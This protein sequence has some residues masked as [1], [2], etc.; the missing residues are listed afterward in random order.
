MPELPRDEEVQ[1]VI[2]LD[3]VTTGFTSPP[4]L[5]AAH[6]LDREFTIQA[7]SQRVLVLRRFL[8]HRL[9]VASLVVL[10]LFI[11]M[12]FVGGPLWKYSYADLVANPY[13]T[14]TWSHPLGSDQIGH[15]ELS[16]VLRGAQASLVV[17]FLVALIA[18]T[19]GTLVGAF[20]GFFGGVV[21]SV[22]MRIC[23]TILTLPT[24]AVAIVL[25]HNLTAISFV[26]QRVALAFI[27]GLLSWPQMARVVRGQLLSLRERDFV[28][29]ARALG[30]SNTRI[31]VRHLVPNVLGSI[32]VN[33]TIYV[34]VAILAESA[35]SFLGFGIQP[36]DT[37][38][39]LLISSAETE[40]SVHPW[41]F[42]SPGLAIIIVAL[43]V[44][45]IGDGLR[46]AFDPGQTQVRA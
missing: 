27:L 24:I 32:I 19:V 42:Y 10:A 33:S 14:P 38:L 44:N 16:L 13:Q 12:A 23:D 40:V 46:D 6:V 26:S 29:A 41:L 37:S 9:A 35:L 8:Q 28:L 18:V 30:A 5:G 22:L 3:A 11:L 20:A 31:I 21:D 2:E 7:R 39:G 25:G 36:P 43:T 17:A 34:S 4:T 45:F 15:D 1:T